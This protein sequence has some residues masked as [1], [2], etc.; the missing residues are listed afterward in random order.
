[1]SEHL[2]GSSLVRQPS[3]RG[4]VLMVQ[5]PAKCVPA[6]TRLKGKYSAIKTIEIIN[7]LLLDSSTRHLVGLLDELRQR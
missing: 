1:M 3:L 2:P 6:P 7:M 4:V 5:M